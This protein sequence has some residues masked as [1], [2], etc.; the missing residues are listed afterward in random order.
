MKKIF[1]VFLLIVILSGSFCALNVHAE[2]VKASLSKL[3]DVVYPG[4]TFSVGVVASGSNITIM[5]GNPIE[6]NHDKLEMTGTPKPGIDSWTYMEGGKSFIVEKPWGGSNASGSSIVLVRFTFKLKDSVKVG[7]SINLQIANAKISTAD[8][9][10]ENGFQSD[11]NC[12][13]K[14]VERPKSTNAN[15]MSLTV[16]DYTLDPSFD[17]SVTDYHM[18]VPHTVTSVSLHPQ[19]AN[20]AATYKTEGA[21]GLEYGEN[22]V[23]ITVTAES[24]AVKI[25]TVAVTRTPP[26]STDT[27]LS[28]LT[29]SPYEIEPAFDPSVTTYAL[30]VP[31]DVFS[32]TPEV[33]TADDKARF[34]IAGN[35]D[36][37]VGENM[38][39]I[40]VTAEDGVS[41]AVY[42][43]KVNRAR[44]IETDS[45][46]KALSFG[47]YALSPAFDPALET[48]SYTL[49][50]PYEID[51]P[52][53]FAFEK[54]GLYASVE[55]S[56][57]DA[58][59]VGDNLFTVVC[60]AEDGEHQTTYTLNVIREARIPNSDA[61]L[62]KL[63]CDHGILTPKFS[64]GI[65]SYV[66]VTE[67]EPGELT[68]ISETNDPLAS[69]QPF[70]FTPVDGMN[71]HV[72][73]V[74]AENGE[75]LDYTVYI[76]TPTP[77]PRCI[78][79]IGTP[80]VGATLR[81]EIEG[82]GEGG[83]YVWT[84]GESEA[85][86][87]GSSYT[88]QEEDAGKQIYV[89]YTDKS[90]HTASSQPVRV[91]EKE[92]DPKQ[93]PSDEPEPKPFRMTELIV[94]I[95]LAVFCLL[96][97]ILIGIF[98]TR[99]KIRKKT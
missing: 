43:L 16:D 55:T 37:I 71:E 95:A 9:S 6:Y 32:I 24:G 85:S 48:Q 58:L 49:S 21:S 68:F 74:T 20:G 44:P 19:P 59:L 12:S 11:L 35:S 97:G 66:L 7:D 81:T 64:P 52:S 29:V 50:V 89:T 86:V 73:T 77:A 82:M 39:L 60:K 27:A 88:V 75:T 10:E 83:S 84:V 3:T 25:Y 47:D 30:S 51:D 91:P 5:Q 62:K 90:G 13:F 34:E 8:G 65:F 96:A 57:P 14:V 93:Q 92:Q 63:S 67:E 22:E 26:P 15:L 38:V 69:V 56:L 98:F 31:A 99:R 17:P 94:A 4:C 53:L 18:T 28:A 54:N 41:K 70:A 33:K 79:L 23:K 45:T 61:T 72:F 87:G 76:F 78:F 1:S 40:T 42:T 2:A 36:F 80:D 46:L